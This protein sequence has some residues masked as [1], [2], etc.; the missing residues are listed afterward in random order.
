LSAP[1]KNLGLPLTMVENNSCQ[2][3]HP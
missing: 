2:F 3:L 1:M